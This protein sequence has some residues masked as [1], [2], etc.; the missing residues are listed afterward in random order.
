M[1]TTHQYQHIRRESECARRRGKPF[2]R[3]NVIFGRNILR[4]NRFLKKHQIWDLVRIVEV[5][6][7]RMYVGFAYFAGPSWAGLYARPDEVLRRL[8]YGEFA[9]HPDRIPMQRALLGS[10]HGRS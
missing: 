6:L 3:V 5:L 7:L 1:P 4:H 2:H 8:C 9:I 10:P